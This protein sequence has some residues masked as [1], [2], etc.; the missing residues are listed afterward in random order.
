MTG[1]AICV[2]KEEKKQRWERQKEPLLY[3]CVTDR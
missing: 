3:A 1:I 2:E